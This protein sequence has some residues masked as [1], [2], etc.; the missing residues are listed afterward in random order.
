VQNLTPEGPA[1]KGKLEKDDVIREING[2]KIDRSTELINTISAIHPGETARIKLWRRG[3]PMD[4]DIVVGEYPGQLA[5][6]YGRDYLG[7]HVDTLEL[8]PE[9]MQERGIKEQPSDFYVA[10]VVPGGAAEAA[11]IRRGDLVVEIGYD[12]ITSLVEFKKTLKKEAKPGKAL[13]LKVW[14]LTEKEPRKVFV[15][16]PEGFTLD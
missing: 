3:A 11:G 7:M 5:A 1:E 9:F 10:G 16:V 12:A 15:K 8:N 13:L 14:T 4:L 6:R 2:K